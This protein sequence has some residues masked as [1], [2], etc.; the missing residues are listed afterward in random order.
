MNDFHYI[1]ILLDM[2]YGIELEEDE[3]EEL[4]LIAYGKIGNKNSRLYSIK[5]CT[6]SDNSIKLP[7]NVS[8]VEAVTIPCE[9]WKR[10]TNYS[11]NGDQNT[12]FIEASIEAEKQF[13]SP[14]Y[15]S[16]KLVDYEQVGDILY[17]SKNYGTLNIL[18]KG[19]NDKDGLPFLTDKEANAIATFI[20]W[21]H[22]Y[23]EG[24]KTN[25][26]NTLNIAKDLEDKWNKQCDQARVG[27]L[28]QNDMDKILDI[29]TSWDRKSYGY[30]YKIIK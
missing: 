24:L 5:V 9:D 13:T 7:C 8:S 6:N 23:K 14:Y 3:V 30:G 12:Q 19:T 21:V 29:K 2:L 28:S 27:K 25:N 4:G 11:E 16:G 17:F 1:I 18:Y 10:T 22:T 20:A 15:V 26:T